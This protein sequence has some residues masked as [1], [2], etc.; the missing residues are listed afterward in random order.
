MKNNMLKLDSKKI[1]FAIAVLLAFLFPVLI[2]NAYY[3]RILIMAMIYILL[4][5]SLNLLIGHLGLFSMGHAAFYC[6]GAYTSGLLSTRLGVPFPICMLAAGILAAFAGF[7]IGFAT[8]RLSDIFFTFATLFKI[9]RSV[10][11][12][13]HQQRDRRLLA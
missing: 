6:I 4:T 11:V 2:D 12:R 3:Q 1:A 13:N 8:L 9:T 7:L 5:S 10:Q